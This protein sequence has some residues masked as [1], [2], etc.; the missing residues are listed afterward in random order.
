MFLVPYQRNS[1]SQLVFTTPP[2]KVVADFTQNKSFQQT[3]L[4]RSLTLT[5]LRRLILT[6]N[7][8][9]HP[10]H[11]N[12]DQ[13]ISHFPYFGKFPLREVPNYPAVNSRSATQRH[14]TTTFLV[15]GKKKKVDR[16]FSPLL[17]LI[18]LNLKRKENS[19]K[20]TYPQIGV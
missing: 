10:I 3:Q 9:A 7:S 17:L 6:R 1:Q 13:T 14:R 2:R 8:N 4:R 19:D 15:R 16:F 11:L 20:A 12:T 18:F 5:T